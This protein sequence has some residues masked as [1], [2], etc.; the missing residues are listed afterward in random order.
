MINIKYIRASHHTHGCL[1]SDNPIAHQDCVL[2]FHGFLM[3]IDCDKC[4]L[5]SEEGTKKP[6]LL[7][8][9]RHNNHHEW[10]VIE[11]KRQL[12]TRALNKAWEQVQSGLN[13]IAGHPDLFGESNTYRLQVIFAYTYRR[14]AAD[15]SQYRQPLKANGIVIPPLVRKCGGER[16]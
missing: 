12:N 9:R 13:T 15:I 6:D 4:K 8:F 3:A 1:I 2:E 10:Y 7:V 14:R 11:I 16:I 5:F